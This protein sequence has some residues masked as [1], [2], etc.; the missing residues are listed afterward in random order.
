MESKAPKKKPYSRP[1]VT[2]LIPEQA[3][4]LVADRKNCSEEE[5]AYCGDPEVYRSRTDRLT[6]LNRACGFLLLQAWR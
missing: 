4:K 1:T 3:K 5:A 2:K 6:W